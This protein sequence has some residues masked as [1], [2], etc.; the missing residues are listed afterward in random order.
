MKLNMKSKA[1]G[2]AAVTGALVMV[3]GTS[4]VA[5]GVNV[6]VSVWGS[7]AAGTH[8][9]DAATTSGVAFAAGSATMSCVSSS[10]AATD[11]A[12]V[13]SGPAASV[14]NVVQLPVVKFNTCTG[15]GGSN[16]VTQLTTP[17]NL[18][19]T[20]GQTAGS[21][22]I[23]VGHVD[24]VSARVSTAI[25]S[26]CT[27]TVAGRASA[28]YNEATGVLSVNESGMTGNLTIGSV[29]GCGGN[30]EIGDP[31]DFV[32]NYQVSKVA[33]SNFAAGAINVF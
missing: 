29:T 16:T 20:S 32:A 30:F 17:W 9:L 8:S 5:S 3:A 11:G 7:S 25:S 27:F 14:L 23:L 19:V 18:H 6:G 12:I 4:A 22:D 2:I 21:T 28:T 33:S 13:N 24:N 26:V 10:V 1:V 15:P 31:A